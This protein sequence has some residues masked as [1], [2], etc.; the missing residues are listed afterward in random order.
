[1]CW[2][3]IKYKLGTSSSSVLGIVRYQNYNWS[4]GDRL[5][6]IHL[7]YDA[8]LGSSAQISGDH[9]CLYMDLTRPPQI[10]NSWCIYE[11]YHL[12]AVKR[13]LYILRHIILW[14]H[15]AL[16]PM[17][18]FILDNLCLISGWKVIYILL[19]LLHELDLVCCW[20]CECLF[21]WMLW[22]MNVEFV[23]EDMQFV[24]RFLL[25]WVVCKLWTV[26]LGW[27]YVGCSSGGLVGV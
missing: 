11:E 23:V 4:Y 18:F 26:R 9:S 27:F 19:P 3:E 15:I 21:V 25:R 6:E 2:Q 10:I 1:M 17:T 14:C 13:V 24:R 8:A 7:I 16:C 22:L 5:C 20:Y 12:Y